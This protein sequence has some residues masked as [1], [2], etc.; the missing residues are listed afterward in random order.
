[1]QQVIKMK[2]FHPQFKEQVKT[3]KV[4]WVGSLKP[5]G[6][7]SRYVIKVE[8][9]LGLSP[10]VS[11]VTPSLRSRADGVR[12]PHIYKGNYPC[13]YFPWSKEKEWTP[14]KHIAMTIIPWASLWLYYYEV[15]HATGVWEGGGID[16]DVTEKRK[17]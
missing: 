12:I 5:S 3:N 11:V 6:L 2:A 8:Y 15:W 4:T 17:S 10:R 14:N 7:T 1:M 9:E 13:L 16:H